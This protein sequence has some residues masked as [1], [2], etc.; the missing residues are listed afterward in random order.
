MVKLIP[1]FALFLLVV[2]FYVYRGVR[3]AMGD[4]PLWIRKTVKWIYWTISAVFVGGLLIYYL[5]LP[6]KL[7]NTLRVII[8]SGLVIGTY[9]SGFCV[10]SVDADHEGNS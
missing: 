10:I 7:A 9:L 3:A 1:L 6:V 8:A 4:F 5:G 2:D